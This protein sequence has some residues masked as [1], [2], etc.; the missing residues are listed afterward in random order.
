MENKIKIWNLKLWNR[1]PNVENRKIDI[2]RN[3]QIIPIRAKERIK[4][5]DPYHNIL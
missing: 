4:K 5:N 2:E 3:E 1:E